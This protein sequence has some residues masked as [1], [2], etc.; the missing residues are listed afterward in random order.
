[1]NSERR[2]CHL[3]AAWAVLVALSGCG[4]SPV[5]RRDP[6][7][8]DYGRT[9]CAES[10]R[11]ETPYALNFIDVDEKGNFKD[12]HQLEQALGYVHQS[13]QDR[14]NI[15]VVVF[16]HG[17]FHSDAPADR[18]VN[19]ARQVLWWF[20][21]NHP[22][23]HVEG[24]YVGWPAWT[25]WPTPLQYLTFW[26]R[27]DNADA[28]GGKGGALQEIVSQLDNAVPDTEHSKLLF[29]GHSFGGRALYRATEGTLRERLEN[30]VTA[31]DQINPQPSAHDANLPQNQQHPVKGVGS[32]VVLLEPAT[33]ADEFV[34]L[35]NASNDAYRHTMKPSTPSRAGI[36]SKNDRPLLVSVTGDADEAVKIALPLSR[37]FTK[38]AKGT[39][40]L[41]PWESDKQ[42]RE[43]KTE[44]LQN[45]AFGR[46]DGGMVTHRIEGN[47]SVDN[48]CSNTHT[49]DYG[50]IE[51][52]PFRDVP[53]YQLPKGW[54]EC[55]VREQ[56]LRDTRTK[57]GT[58]FERLVVPDS[59]LQLRHLGITSPFN[60]YWNASAHLDVIQGHS[61]LMNQSVI[62]FINQMLFSEQY[63][64]EV[65]STECSWMRDGKP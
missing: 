12:H 2:F 60:P 49:V 10:M 26:N 48:K 15:L 23:W 4:S 21:A 19:R 22:L 9:A 38:S 29:I 17:W 43:I 1:M 61:K 36:F 31:W 54:L 6:K 57:S 34:K 35:Y 16:V 41:Q 8:C 64:N 11:E 7:A 45:Q 24:I 25:D 3:L 42:P 52:L 27:K 65:P 39:T 14:T 62:E 5:T 32:L 53:R 44:T 30:A 58:K 40:T 51:P 28:L 37:V 46:H 63:E 18:D 20:A 33:T 56:S 50:G 59:C 47:G 55:A 13:P